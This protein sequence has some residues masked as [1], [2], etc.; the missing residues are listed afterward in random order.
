MVPL[1][2]AAAIGGHLEVQLLLEKG[3]DPNYRDRNGWSAIPWAAEEGH[4]DI[5]RLLLD[6]GA[7]AN[8]VSSYGTSP[9]H[10]AANGGKMNIVGLLIQYGAD[11]LRTTC[12]GWTPLHHAAYMGHAHIVQFLLRDYQIRSNTSLQ[13]NHGWSILHLAVHSRDLNTVSSILDSSLIAE[14]R[15]L[16]DENGLTAGEWLD[17]VP[18]SHTYQATSDLAFSKS[19]CCR[20]VTGLRQAVAGAN[21]TMTEFLLGH[22]HFVNG[23]DSG[24]RTALY[25]AAKKS[26][27]PIMDLLLERGADP[28]IL[29][30][31]RKTW[32][33][34]ISDDMALSRLTRAGYKKG[35]TDPEVEQRIRLALRGGGDSLVQ[36]GDRSASGPQHTH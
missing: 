34:F 30:V 12:H 36:V 5:V 29:P 7:D 24:R 21:I 13:D 10:C 4:E 8:S 33:E 16:Y 1:E 32:E 20:A 27:L 26:F 11:P 9:L 17:L 25:Y 15:T 28:N 2:E 31:G 22:G 3:A 14:T 19:R 35:S 23:T 18:T 6:A